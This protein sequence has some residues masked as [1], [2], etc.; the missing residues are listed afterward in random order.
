MI[1][2]EGLTKMFGPKT[3]VDRV[4]FRVERGEVLGFL[5]PN[6]AGKSTTMR[7]ITGY[8]PP[9]AGRAV[10]SGFDVGEQP[11]EAKRRV[12]W[13]ER[14]YCLRT[15]RNPRSSLSGK[16]SIC[17]TRRFNAVWSGRWPMAH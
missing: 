1:L 9:T 10:V 5:G 17:I 13:S 3:A 16:D 2:V 8:L 15:V 14:R 6:G 11:I 12:G 7:M 4:S